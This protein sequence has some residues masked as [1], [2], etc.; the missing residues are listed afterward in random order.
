MYISNKYLNIYFSLVEKRQKTPYTGHPMEIHHII[1]KSLGG[2]NNPE[3]LVNFSAREHYIAHKIMTKITEGINREKMVH[4]LWGMSNRILNNSLHGYMSSRSYENV[5]KL[6]L[7]I[8]GNSLRGKTYEQIHGEEGAKKLK[9][10]R[11]DSIKKV[12]K[13]K[14]W[15][16]IFGKEEAEWRRKRVSAGAIKRTGKPMSDETKQ[17]LRNSHKGKVFAKITCPHCSI[18]IGTNNIKKHLKSHQ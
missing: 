18:A 15:E 3:N 12:R 11:A 14:T 4:A 5:R 16:E 7:E 10:S 6:F 8:A 17:K 13:G 2:G 1:P 9:K